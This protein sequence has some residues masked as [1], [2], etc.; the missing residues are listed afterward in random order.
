MLL[1]FLM[2]RFVWIWLSNFIFWRASEVCVLVL[3]KL[4][5]MHLRR[6]WHLLLA[7]TNHKLNKL[8]H[9]LFLMLKINHLLE[10][11]FFHVYR[12]N[13]NKNT[14]SQVSSFPLFI[15]TGYYSPALVISI[16]LFVCHKESKRGWWCFNMILFSIS[17]NIVFHNQSKV[18][19][20]P[21]VKSLNL[22]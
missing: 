13:S 11:H 4:E 19:I 8:S 22:Y 12:N 2:M 21:R 5:I 3:S 15:L 1:P 18:H 17:L 20:S 9:I 7:Y 6:E 10:I 16:P 14:T